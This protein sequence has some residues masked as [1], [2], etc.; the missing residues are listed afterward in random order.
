MAARDRSYVYGNTA[1]RLK[2]DRRGRDFYVL[3]E[4]SRDIAKRQKKAHAAKIY[5]TVL[6]VVTVVALCSIIWHYINV[7][8]EVTA[9]MSR[10][11]TL[12]SQYEELHLDNDL[13]EDRINS[14]INIQEIER[15]AVEELGMRLAGEGQIV[16][17]SGEIED[18]VKQYA[19]MPE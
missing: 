7:Q 3:P 8:A 1:K 6:V 18:Y 2:E 16:N 10:K 15:I 11:A 4:S 19:D 17:Y 9:L 12:Q 5:N 14:S 13:Y